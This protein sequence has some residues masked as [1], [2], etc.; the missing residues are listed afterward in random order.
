M[1]LYCIDTVVNRDHSYMLSDIALA[2]SRRD[3]GGPCSSTRP[4]GPGLIDTPHEDA[5]MTADE[6]CSAAD[7]GRLWLG[8]QHVSKCYT[9]HLYCAFSVVLFI[10]L[11]IAR[12]P[13]CTLKIKE[14]CGVSMVSDIIHLVFSRVRAVCLPTITHPP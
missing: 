14:V 5:R 4:R 12:R 6:F 10:P 1:M 7:E 11:F 3:C 13:V 9:H 8:G 2:T